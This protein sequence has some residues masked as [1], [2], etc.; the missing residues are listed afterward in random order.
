MDAGHVVDE[1]LPEN[2]ITS[3]GIGL[4]YSAG[5][6]LRFDAI[7]ANAFNEVVPEQE[8][9]QLFAQLEWQW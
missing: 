8:N 2:T 4:S 9:G 6:P 7:Y 1:D 3:A 5:G